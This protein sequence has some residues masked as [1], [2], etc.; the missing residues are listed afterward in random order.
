MDI[1]VL[2]MGR[3]G[4]ALARRLLGGGHS[5]VVWNRSPGKADEVVAAGAKEAGSIAEAVDGAEVVITSLSDDEAVEAVALG[6]GGV[7]SAIGADAV[8][9]DASTVSPAMSERLASAF[10]RFVALPI[11]GAPAAVESG[12]ATYLAGG[13]PAV[14]GRLDPVLAALTSTVRRYD[15][16]A[17]AG[18]AKLAS[19]LMLLAEVAA[20]AEAVTVARSGGLGDDEVRALLGESPMLAPGVENRFDGVLTGEME[21]WWTT[22]LGAKDAGLAAGAARAA[23]VDLP[24]AE[25]VEALYGQAAESGAADEDIIAVAARYRSGG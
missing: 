25:L 15:T 5:V 8:Y 7:R 17:K 2:G 3:M 1:A 6:D 13:D 10:P 23:G 19:N 20:L 12:K 9:A 21:A 11:L 4:Q 16:P 22:A 18:H 14:V 24:L